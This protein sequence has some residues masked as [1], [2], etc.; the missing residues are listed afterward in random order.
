M[1]ANFWDLACK[2]RFRKYQNK[3]K[4][5]IMQKIWSEDTKKM[6]CPKIIEPSPSS[7]PQTNAI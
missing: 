7:L 3:T 2:Y 6:H 5:K 1:S 4:I